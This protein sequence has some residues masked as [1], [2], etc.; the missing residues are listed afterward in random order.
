M[1]INHSSTNVPPAMSQEAHLQNGFSDDGS[2]IDGSDDDYNN[3]C[4]IESPA[5]S[6]RIDYSSRFHDDV[7]NM[8]GHVYNAYD[9]T[10]PRAKELVSIIAA[11]KNCRERGVAV[12]RALDKMI[13]EEKEDLASEKPPP[14][15]GFVSSCAVGKVRKTKVSQWSGTW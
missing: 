10:I 14:L 12:E 13:S 3:G 11:S 8:G 9:M 6:D 2:D 7:L 15:G 1:V 4:L 5:R